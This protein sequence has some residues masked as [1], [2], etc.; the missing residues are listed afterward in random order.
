[1]RLPASGT[2]LRRFAFAPSCNL[3]G[4][5]ERND[6]TLRFWYKRKPE[7]EGRKPN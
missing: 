6:L 4:N 3:F 2:R 5:A 7:A 1:M